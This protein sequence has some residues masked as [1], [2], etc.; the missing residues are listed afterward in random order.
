MSDARAIRPVHDGAVGADD[1]HDAAVF[2]RTFFHFV[3]FQTLGVPS[4]D[5]A[6]QSPRGGR[7]E[8]GGVARL[9]VLQE[10]KD[11]R[12]ALEN[13]AY[14]AQSS[15]TLEREGSGAIWFWFHL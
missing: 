8:L 3:R 12:C 9:W 13:V 15:D 7:A 6:L 1:V 14:G 2:Q 5:V 11:G 4:G 10:R